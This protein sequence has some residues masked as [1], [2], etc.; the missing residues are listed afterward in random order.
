MP[1]LIPDRH[2]Q[3]ELFSIGQCATRTPYWFT[4]SAA[5]LVFEQLALQL[6][7]NIIVENLTGAGGT[8]GSG[9]VARAEPDGYTIL[10]H[11]SAHTIAPALYSSLP[12]HPARDFA[13]VVPLGISPVVLESTAQ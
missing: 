5:R 9:M 10:A 13:A 2:K 6:G 3:S 1:L 4:S 7:Q 8:I 11:G 12:Y